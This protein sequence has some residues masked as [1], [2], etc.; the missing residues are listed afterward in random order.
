MVAVERGKPV[1][2][3]VAPVRYGVVRGFPAFVVKRAWFGITAPLAGW[4]GD[5]R[6]Y[7]AVSGGHH[8]SSSDKADGDQRETAP[9]RPSTRISSPATAAASASTTFRLE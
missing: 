3:R 6:Q 2:K 8:A 1:I 7:R 9:C 5:F 4:G